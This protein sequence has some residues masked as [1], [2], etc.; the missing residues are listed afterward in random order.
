M[1]RNFSLIFCG[2][3]LLCMCAGELVAAD[4]ASVSQARRRLVRAVSAGS[5]QDCIA[6]IKEL[7]PA[8]KEGTEALLS[9][10]KRM[11]ERMDRFYWLILDGMAVFRSPEA[12]SVIGDAIIRYRAQPLGRDLLLALE[13]CRSR[14]VIRVVRRVLK[15]GTAEMK[16]SAL[17]IAARIPVRRTVDVLLDALEK[18]LARPQGDMKYRIIEV[19]ESLTGVNHGEGMV[20]WRLW[21]K[22]KR[23][24]GLSRIKGEERFT[25]TVVDHLD[26]LRLQQ[27]VGLEKRSPGWALVITASKNEIA[28]DRI[29]DVMERMKIPRTVVTK[30]QFS[31]PRFQM[32]DVRVIVINC[33]MWREFCRNPDHHPG[34]DSGEPRLQRCVGPGPHQMKGY[35]FSNEAVA[36]LKAF[37]E[38][39]GYLFTEDMVLEELLSKAWPKFVGVG[40]FLKESTVEVRPGRGAGSHPYLKGVFTPL[41]RA[42]SNPFEI[43]EEAVPKEY[44]IPESAEDNE[45]EGGPRTRVVGRDDASDDKI[46]IEPLRRHWKIDDDSP[47]IA[48]QNRRAV[49]LLLASDGVKAGGS[50]AVALTFQPRGRRGGAVL[51]VL[52]HF[53]KQRSQDDEFALQNMLLNF[54]LEAHARYPE[55]KKE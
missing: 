49:Q 11:P 46:T 20:N 53:G 4:D 30:E 35:A 26:P 14:F 10:V 38:R 48:I 9:V 13:S 37:V 22:K 41:G 8:G 33:M 24:K 6:A 25:R 32:K 15:S 45:E 34:G 17:G 16:H 39:G 28:F 29:E 54:M 1:L 47:G 55:K 19:L 3:A 12:Y 31:D 21:W 36:K 50:R 2:V 40:N 27:F 42:E 18:E 43:E 52:S 23:A 7:I 51:H 5:E 44:D